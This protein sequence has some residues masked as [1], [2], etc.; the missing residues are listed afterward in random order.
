MGVPIREPPDLDVV[1]IRV[2][3]ILR[4][5]IA[6]TSIA[7]HS[8]TPQNLSIESHFAGMMHDPN[9][10]DNYRMVKNILAVFKV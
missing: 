9:P 3:P 6:P 8:L 10:A 4:H 5:S 1:W 7:H 2:L